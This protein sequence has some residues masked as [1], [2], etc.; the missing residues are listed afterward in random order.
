LNYLEEYRKAVS[1]VTPQQV[2]EVA[3]K[4]L[5]PDRLIVVAVGDIDQDGKP[6][7]KSE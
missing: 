4:Y 7:K 1:S 3:K 5:D 6:T 2:Q